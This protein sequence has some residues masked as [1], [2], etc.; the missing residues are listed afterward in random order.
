MPPSKTRKK[1]V[2][3]SLEEEAKLFIKHYGSTMESLA[4]EETKS[5]KK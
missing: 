3:K 2:V 1:K 5:N 4:K